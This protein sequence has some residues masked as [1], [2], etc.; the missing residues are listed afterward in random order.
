M[1]SLGFIYNLICATCGF[2]MM[3][4][5]EWKVMGLAAY[6][7]MDKE[8]YKTLR[9]MVE[10]D[11]VTIKALVDESV[12]FFVLKKLYKSRRKKG[13]SPFA[14]ANVAYTGQQVFSEIYFQFLN[15][16]YDLG[17]S[18]NLV[19]GGGCALNSSA[20]G[21]IIDKTKFKKAHVFSAPGDDGNALGAACLA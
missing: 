9:Q 2:G 21:K 8:L 18:E 13:D 7:E 10:V 1:G 12:I 3:T 11:G 5:E 17:I 6:G 16:L 4:G 14:S 15:N 19:L 20:N